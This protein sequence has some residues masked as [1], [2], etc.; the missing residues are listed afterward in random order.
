MPAEILK[1]CTQ[2]TVKSSVLYMESYLYLTEA[3][4]IKKCSKTIELPVI[5]LALFTMFYAYYVIGPCLGKGHQSE[6][7]RYQ[8][9]LKALIRMYLRSQ[10]NTHI[11]NIHCRKLW[12]IVTEND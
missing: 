10:N 9:N 6:W 12:G 3:Y 8:N 1:G 2:L 5:V 4:N 7:M 11:T